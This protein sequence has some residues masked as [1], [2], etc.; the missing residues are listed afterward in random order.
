MACESWGDDPTIGGRKI[1]GMKIIVMGCGRVG[2]RLANTLDAEGHQV[3]VIDRNVASFRRLREGFTG[4]TVLGTGI[5][6]DVLR[7]AGVE[8]ADVFVATTEGDN[9]NLMSAQIAQRVFN[10][11]M[12]IARTYD[13]GRS[14]IYEKLGLKTY[15]PTLVGARLLHEMILGKE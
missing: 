6:E 8:D 10:V 2:S 14:E 12:V 13:P 1:E 15:C 7:R 4:T 5:D 11:P 9:R 3:T